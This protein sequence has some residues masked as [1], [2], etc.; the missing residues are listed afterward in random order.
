M[1]AES[2]ARLLESAMKLIVQGGV[3]AASI[4][5]ICEGAGFSQGAFYSYFASKDDVLFT[6]VEDHMGALV[7]SFEAII[8]TSPAA[9]LDALLDAMTTSLGTLSLQPE[10]SILVI[11]LHLHAR[12]DARFR[13]RF[14]PV[15]RAYENAF[16]GVT[17]HLLQRAGL[18]AEMPSD[19]VARIL[20]ALWSGSTLRA[21]DPAEIST[22][23]GQVFAALAHMHGDAMMTEEHRRSSLSPSGSA[24]S[25]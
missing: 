4:R 11:E 2:R 17:E 13:S 23:M 5:G 6:L 20:L 3:A 8:A 24:R 1:R 15:R 14:E 10:R 21:R 12:R 9:T 7:R 16:T 25:S 18:K 22:Q 19:Q